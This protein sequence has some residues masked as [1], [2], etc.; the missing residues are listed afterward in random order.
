MPVWIWCLTVTL[1]SLVLILI[2]Q[3]LRIGRVAE[4]DEGRF[5]DL[6]IGSSLEADTKCVEAP[7]N[8][9]CDN[10]VE[11]QGKGEW[12]DKFHIYHDGVGKICA[13]RVDH[14]SPWGLELTLRCR[15]VEHASSDDWSAVVV[16][17]NTKDQPGTSTKCV[18]APPDVICDNS[19]TQLGRTGQW[20][21]TFDIYHKDGQVCAHRTDRPTSWGLDLI[22]QCRKG[23]HVAEVTFTDITIG[24][25][26]D[27]KSNE[28]CVD[29]PGTVLCDNSAEQVGRDGRYKDKFNI[30]SKDGQIC[31]HRTDETG[32]W[33]L[34]LVLRCKN[35][36]HHN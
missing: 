18:E 14:P 2:M 15:V 8:V 25:T 6:Y 32:P 28:K 5:Y 26:L 33:G 9:L 10:D 4:M 19:A 27:T 21:D 34:N 3:Q 29:D 16:I 20:D 31:A 7:G 22:L 30:F 36:V 23:T 11:Q 13:K 24:N 1:L 12:P 17:G 35:K